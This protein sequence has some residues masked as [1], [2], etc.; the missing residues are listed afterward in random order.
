M[1]YSDKIDENQTVAKKCLN[2]GAYNAGVSRAYYA[3]F[4]KAK[5]FCFYLIIIM[6]KGKK[7]TE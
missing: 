7:F 5:M 1:S 3:A 4:L 2:M 6:K